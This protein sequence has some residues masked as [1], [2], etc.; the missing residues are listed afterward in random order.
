MYPLA[1][2][3]PFVMKEFAEELGAAMPFIADGSGDFTRALDAGVDLSDHGLGYRSRRFTAVIENGV[4]TAVN[5]ENGPG[6]SDTSKADT[7]LKGL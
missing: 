4:V 5:D 2:N 3:D 7:V 1:I 6:F